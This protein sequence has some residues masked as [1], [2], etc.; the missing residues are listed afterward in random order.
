MLF[1]IIKSVSL[2][3]YDHFSDIIQTSFKFISNLIEYWNLRIEIYSGFDGC[4]N[5][6]F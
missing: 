6:V 5:F 2:K 4:L 1:R 3:V